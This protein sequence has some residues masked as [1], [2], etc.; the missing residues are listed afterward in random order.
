MS[1]TADRK[2]H[3]REIAREQ[4]K[5][6]EQHSRVVA[7]ANRCGHYIDCDSGRDE[8]IAVAQHLGASEQDA[9]LVSSHFG[10]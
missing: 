4:V 8:I 7:I 10:R 6:D 1:N 5:R 3:Q 2:R 9:L